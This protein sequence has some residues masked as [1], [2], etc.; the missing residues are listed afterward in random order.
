MKI[1]MYCKDLSLGGLE[2]HLLTLCEELQAQGN[3]IW[4]TAESI[5]SEMKE[6]FEGL[7]IPCFK[8]NT[9]SIIRLVREECIDLIHLHPWEETLGVEQVL[10]ET[11]LPLVVTCHGLKKEIIPALAD[12]AFAFICVSEA[13]RS[14]INLLLPPDKTVVIYNPVDMSRFH[15]GLAE[16]EGNIILFAARLS[17]DKFRAAN[18]LADILG[19]L[20]GAKLWVLGDGSRRKKIHRKGE[21][22][23]LGADLRPE[24]I[25]SQASIICGESRVVMEAMALGKPALVLG[26]NGYR[27][28]VT[29]GSLHTLE[30][31][32]FMCLEQGELSLKKLKKDLS[33]LLK[34]SGERQ[35]IGGYG[36]VYAVNRYDSKKIT[37]DIL[38]VYQMATGDYKTVE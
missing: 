31:D 33:Y 1:L 12:K 2:T 15:P 32:N 37:R 19:E 13:V 27:G 20:P 25:M 18:Y 26:N 38:R 8:I 24:A 22:S 16:E 14:Y 11:G 3:Q 29:K 23:L 6:N 28:I 5:G 4:V 21:V 7:Q 35:A 34:H 10:E 30:K 17:K 36:R 9:K